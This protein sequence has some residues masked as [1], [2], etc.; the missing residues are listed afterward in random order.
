VWRDP[1]LTHFTFVGQHGCQ[2]ELLGSVQYQTDIKND[3]AIAQSNLGLLTKTLELSILLGIFVL[4]LSDMWRTT[5]SGLSRHMAQF[6]HSDFCEW[7]VAFAF[8]PTG[9]INLDDKHVQIR[10]LTAVSCIAAGP[11]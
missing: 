8:S 2:F 6:S 5:T 1:S 11:M 3:A 4:S 7:Q 10:Y 9:H